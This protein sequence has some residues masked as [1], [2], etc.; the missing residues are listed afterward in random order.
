MS[1]R[2]PSPNFRRPLVALVRSPTEAVPLEARAASSEHLLVQSFLIT[3]SDT[4]ENLGDADADASVIIEAIVNAF[5]NCADLWLPSGTTT[6]SPPT[7]E[8]LNAAMTAGSRILLIGDPPRPW[9]AAA[10]RPTGWSRRLAAARGLQLH[11]SIA[12]GRQAREMVDALTQW[13]EEFNE[14]HI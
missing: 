9:D 3:E 8:T 10:G 2:S 1:T 13:L 4:P 11:E 7:C 14:G 6:M 12:T 5:D